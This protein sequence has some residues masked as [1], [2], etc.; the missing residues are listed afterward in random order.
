MIENT[1][2]NDRCPMLAEVVFYLLEL[3][4]VSHK[5]IP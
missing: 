4:I 1:L 5:P 3:S 2:Y